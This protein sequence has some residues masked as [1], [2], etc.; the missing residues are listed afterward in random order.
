MV[1]LSGLPEWAKGMLSA[2]TM[3]TGISFF[4]SFPAKSAI[5]SASVRSDTAM[6]AGTRHS[7]MQNKAI[8]RFIRS[9]PLKDS[10]LVWDGRTASYTA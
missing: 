6:A 5:H 1:C 9:I 10:G 8:S 2:S 4:G 7:V 3:R